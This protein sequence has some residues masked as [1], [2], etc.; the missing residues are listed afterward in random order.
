MQE[1]EAKR[2]FEEAIVFVQE[3]LALLASEDYVAACARLHLE[4]ELGPWTPESLFQVIASCGLP[5]EPFVDEGFRV[6][7]LDDPSL[8]S[9]PGRAGAG[10]SLAWRLAMSRAGRWH[11]EHQFPHVHATLS[12]PHPMPSGPLPRSA[13][14]S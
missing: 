5:A 8:G 2:I 9:C 4:P 13:R 14:G 11:F 7:P 6:T 1:P 3:W 12:A 10:D